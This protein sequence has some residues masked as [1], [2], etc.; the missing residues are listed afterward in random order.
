LYK[1]SL[2]GISGRHDAIALVNMGQIFIS[3][4]QF[5]MA[6]ACLVKA[7]GLS[8]EMWQL[9]YQLSA[10]ASARGDTAAAASWLQKVRAVDPYALTP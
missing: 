1:K 7:R 6:E 9:Y 2:S 3:K 4:G 5:K 8:P 10:L